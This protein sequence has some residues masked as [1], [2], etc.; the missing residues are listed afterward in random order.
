MTKQEAVR[1]IASE[2]TRWMMKHKKPIT[3]RVLRPIL[4]R[5]LPDETGLEQLTDYL[6]SKAGKRVW[7]ATM[8]TT[9]KEK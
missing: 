7:H 8:S 5:H 1:R 4:E 9:L 6:Q 3:S 2:A